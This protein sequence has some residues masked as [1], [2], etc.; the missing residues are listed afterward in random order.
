MLVVEGVATIQIQEAM[1]EQVE[2]AVV[3]QVLLQHHLV[4]LQ[5]QEQQDS[6]VAV[7]DQVKAVHN[8]NL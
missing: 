4:Q 3:A 1:R 6:V 2:L 8:H 5:Q 7:V